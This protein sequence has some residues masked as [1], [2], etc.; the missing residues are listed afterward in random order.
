[1]AEN[2]IW[3]CS[4]EKRISSSAMHLKGAEASAVAYSILESEKSNEIKPFVYLQHVLVQ[5][6]YLRKPSPNEELESFIP[7]TPY[8]H[9]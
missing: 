8:V 6:P 1:M 4:L 2:V 7:W 5:L 3:M 9:L